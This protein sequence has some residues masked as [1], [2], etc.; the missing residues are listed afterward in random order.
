MRFYELE[1]LCQTGH[2]ADVLH[3]LKAYWGSMLRLGATTFWEKYNPDETGAQHLAMYG[4]P[5]G[6]S[7]CHAW[8]ASPLYII[9]KY[10]LGVRPTQP[11]Y[12]QYEVRPTLAGLRWMEGDV[13]TPFGLIHVELDGTRCTVS[14]DGGRGTLIV[15]DRQIEIPPKQ[16]IHTDLQ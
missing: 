2:H 12:A 8:G 10:M 9:G 11:G 13:P 3:Q 7:L 16:T 5:Y 4:R 15:G 1:A 6:K 14:S